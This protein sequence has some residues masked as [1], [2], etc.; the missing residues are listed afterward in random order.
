M[1]AELGKSVTPVTCI[2]QCELTIAPFAEFVFQFLTIIATFWDDVL[3]VPII[4]SSSF[5]HFMP[6]LDHLLE[7]IV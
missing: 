7:F 6:A 5:L 4:V 1:P 3:V 2:Y